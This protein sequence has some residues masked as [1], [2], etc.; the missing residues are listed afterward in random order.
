MEPRRKRCGDVVNVRE[1]DGF[2]DFIL[3][4]E[5]GDVSTA[6]N[7]FTWYILDGKAI[8]KL[9]NF[10]MSEDFLLMWNISCQ[11]VGLRDISYHTPI[12]IKGNNL[13]WEPKLFKL[14]NYWMKNDELVPLIKNLWESNT[15]EGKAA[16]VL[17]EKLRL[18]RGVLRK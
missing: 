18:L 17:K 2:G 4:M 7:K 16:Y 6:S 15:I 1:M 11:H 10:L 13:S 9:D 12:W 8:S 5:L 14:F 3:N